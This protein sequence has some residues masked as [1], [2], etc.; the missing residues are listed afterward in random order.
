MK[1]PIALRVLSLTALYC[2]VFVLLVMMQFSNRGSFSLSAG[3]MTIR[4]LYLNNL[5]SSTAKEAGGEIPA[6]TDENA[7]S[8]HAITDGVKIYF[9]GLEFSLEEKRGKGL[10][11]A[12]I[13]G[14]SHVNPEYMAVKDNTARFYL[15]GGTVLIFSST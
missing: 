5:P 1:K 3:A 8:K 4:G 13:N 10:T 12:G 15:P 14:S 2:I 6:V 7:E 11:L 9:G